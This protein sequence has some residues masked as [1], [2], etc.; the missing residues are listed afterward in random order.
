MKI[1]TKVQLLYALAW[2]RSRLKEAGLTREESERLPLEK[3]RI[4]R[5]LDALDHKPRTVN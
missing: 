1:S 3:E 4:E 2:V 5:E